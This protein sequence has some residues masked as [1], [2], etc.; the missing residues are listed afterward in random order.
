M[1]S[2]CDHDNLFFV[3][4]RMKGVICGNEDCQKFWERYRTGTYPNGQMHTVLASGLEKHPGKK[5]K[6]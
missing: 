3:G 5:V 1:A 2:K 4:K 6:K